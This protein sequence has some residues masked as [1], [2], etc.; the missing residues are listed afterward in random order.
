MPAAR[1][2]SLCPEDHVYAVIRSG[3]KQYRVEEGRSVKLD[4]LIGEPGETVE[5]NDVL[6]LAD[7]DD[8]SVGAPIVEGARVLGTIAEQGRSDKI[9]VFRY[10]AKTRSR[11]KTGHRQHFTRVVVEDILAAGQE[12]KPKRAPEPEPA[13]AEEAPK[14]RRGRRRGAEA[15][16]TAEATADAGTITAPDDT[17]AATQAV[18]TELPEAGEAPSVAEPPPAEKPKRRLGRRKKEE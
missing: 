2:V 5:L 18:E 15:T 11:K 12:P 16:E 13:A 6:L 7:G 14:T 8:V 3:G 9:I 1:Q 4:R 17:T 10:K